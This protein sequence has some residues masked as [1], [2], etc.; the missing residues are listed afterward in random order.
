MTVTRETQETLHREILERMRIIGEPSPG[1]FCRVM[2]EEPGL[3]DR[4]LRSCGL[5]VC[6][7]VIDGIDEDSLRV[8]AML[9]N[10]GREMNCEVRFIRGSC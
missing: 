9:E 6:G 1:N 5:D 8:R 4:Y 10:E 2:E 3:L 7:A